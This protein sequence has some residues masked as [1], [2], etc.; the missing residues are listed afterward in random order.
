MHLKKLLKI[1]INITYN[2]IPES[3]KKYQKLKNQTTKKLPKHFTK[4]K[5][6]KKYNK[7]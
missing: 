7:I 4:Y 1:Q 6:F 2:I 5:K 3:Y